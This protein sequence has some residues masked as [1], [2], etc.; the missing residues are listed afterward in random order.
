[1]VA[2]LHLLKSLL[3]YALQIVPQYQGLPDILLL[4]SSCDLRKRSRTADRDR[5]AV[6][7]EQAQRDKTNLPS[8]QYHFWDAR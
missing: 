4:K 1:L 8:G 7:S 5:P 3:N 6:H 2:I